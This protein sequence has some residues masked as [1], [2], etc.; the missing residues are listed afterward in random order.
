[1][2][3]SSSEKKKKSD[4]SGFMDLVTQVSLPSLVVLT[5]YS[6]LNNS[7]SNNRIVWLTNLRRV[8]SELVF[9]YTHLTNL[10]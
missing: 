7:T 3:C 9:K 8:K 1:M 5:K 10:M 2:M 4:L 6:L